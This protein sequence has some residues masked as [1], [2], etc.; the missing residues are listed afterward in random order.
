M[1]KEEASKDLI[2]TLKISFKTA[3]IYN[4][5]HPALKKSVE[6][7]KNK[8]DILF[9]YLSPIKISFTSNSLLIGEKLWEK[10]KIY[11]EMAKL[12]HL[13]KIK[14]IEIIPGVTIEELMT[15]ISKIHLPAKDILQEGGIE[16]I[17]KNERVSHIKVEEYDYYQL[18][19]GEGEEI[20]DIWVY[21]L[22]N[23]LEKGDDQKLIDVTNS[24]EKVIYNFE[25]EDISENKELHENFSRFFSHLKIHN[26]K[27]FLECAKNLVKSAITN[28]NI[29]PEFKF[30]KLSTLVTD[31]KEEELAS[32]LIE[33][34][35]NDDKFDSLS[36]STF[37][38][39]ANKEKHERIASSLKKMIKEN[40]SLHSNPK[41]IEKIGGLFSGTSTPLISEIYRKTLASFL[42]DISSEKKILFDH[43]LLQKNFRFMLLNLLEKEPDKIQ[44]VFLLERIF[45]EKDTITNEKDFEY[46]KFFFEVLK[47]KNEHVSSEY[48]Y[49]KINSFIATY[50]ENAILQGDVSLYFDYFIEEL[51]KSSS[52]VNTYLTKI[53]TENKVTIYILE[54]FFKFFPEYLFYF[55]INLEEKTSDI[56]FLEKMIESLKMIDSPISLIVLKNIYSLGSRSTKIKVLKAMQKL[57]EF[58]EKFLFP[59]LKEKDYTLKGEV[60]LILIKSENMKK[61]ALE[62]MFFI[63]SPF[64]IKNRILIEHIKIVEENKVR[65]AR[66][67]LLPLSKRKF[68][69]NRKLR[70]QA[71]EVLEK[72]N[73]RKN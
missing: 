23:A 12:L 24:F 30:D 33:E 73:D 41:F 39:L 9:N 62:K 53:F 20:K 27:K 42:K 2:S 4:I 18:L 47:Q 14:S 60:L 11:V 22:K 50:I 21:L 25:P 45:K 6:N 34:I 68:F 67:Y 8:I 36:F 51:D 7:L 72:W 66:D 71:I 55:N 15:L 1:D 56:R 52:D 46:F 65:L 44:S 16:N 26:E 29:S 57:S 61:A 3:S 69:W 28:K 35:I 13:R 58:D 48:I 31:L 19:K 10:E 63:R 38:K 17:L 59:I 5:E 43:V 40:V 70:E 32:V 54:A 49:L 64:G 37:S